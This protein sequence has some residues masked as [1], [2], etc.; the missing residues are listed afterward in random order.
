RLTEVIV[1]FARSEM[2]RNLRLVL[3]GRITPMLSAQGMEMIILDLSRDNRAAYLD[4]ERLVWARL[5]ATMEHI[6]ATR[7]RMLTRKIAERAD[8]NMLYANS[9][10][11]E[12]THNLASRQSSTENVDEVLESLTL[13]TGLNEYYL[14]AIKKVLTVDP[15]PWSQVHRPLL[16]ALAVAF[17]P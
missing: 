11:S 10:V 3:T 16:G 8:G 9:A 6:D 14:D 5:S 7:L 2:P 13:P 4:V 17:G 12:L 15:R 1:D